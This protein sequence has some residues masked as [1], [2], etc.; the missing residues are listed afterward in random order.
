VPA[1]AAGGDDD[2]DLGLDDE[3]GFDDGMD[4]AAA[5]AGGQVELDDDWGLDGDE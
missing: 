2:D 3:F 1:A 4:G 5:L